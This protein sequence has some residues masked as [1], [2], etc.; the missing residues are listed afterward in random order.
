MFGND[1]NATGFA[2]LAQQFWQNLQQ[3]AGRPS[4]SAGWPGAGFTMPQGAGSDP[5][6]FFRQAN[7]KPDLSAMFAPFAQWGASQVQADPF[8][9][10]RAGFEQ[11]VG[12]GARMLEGMEFEGAHALRDAL[13]IPGIGPMR[14][15]QERWHA[16]ARARLEFEEVSLR[17]ARHFQELMIKTQQRFQHSLA[18]LSESGKKLESARATLD[19]WVD[20]GE[21]VWAEIAMSEA[22]QRDLGDLTNAQ[23][24][25]QQ[26]VQAQIDR[27]AASCGLPSRIEVDAT[28]RKVAVLERE[29][30]AL[31]AQLKAGESA[32]RET[33]SVRPEPVAGERAVVVPLT[34]V[35]PPKREASAK[36]APRRASA[37][38]KPAAVAKGAKASAGAAQRNAKASAG[39]KAAKAASRGETDHAATVTLFPLVDAPRAF[40]RKLPDAGGSKSEPRGKRKV[41][42]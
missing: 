30:R 34:T 35:T 14:E 20:A 40:G 1:M 29:V 38:R 25:L 39:S 3:M 22:F 18:E 12:Q 27:F 33:T 10:M 26:A 7:A 8:S 2:A 5:F 28:A 31:R 6:A 9:Q 23:M 11:W 37:S 16:I 32:R 13:G 42:K 15:E 4:V 24:R 41:A 17:F 36:P 21:R 19:L